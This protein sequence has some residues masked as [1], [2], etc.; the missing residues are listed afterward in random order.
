[1]GGGELRRGKDRRAGRRRRAEKTDKDA[2]RL[3]DNGDGSGLRQGGDDGK[4]G[5]C[6]CGGGL[7]DGEGDGLCNG[8]DDGRRGRWGHAQLY[9]DVG[10]AVGR[11][12]I[13]YSVGMSIT[14]NV[15]HPR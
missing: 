9:G 8:E 10:E 14:G 4:L 13:R 7:G 12:C 2:S 1:M 5:N 3:R 6:K 15:M 11:L